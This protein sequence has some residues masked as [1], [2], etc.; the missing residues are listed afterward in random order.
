[1]KA[2]ETNLLK[3]LQ[4]T[5]QFIIPIYQRTYSWTQS[6]CQQLWNDIL[7]AGTD[8]EVSGHFI[9]SV[10]YVERGLY[11]ISSVPQ[12]LVIDGQQRLTTLTL[13]LAALGKVIEERELSGETSRKKIDNYYLF[14][15]EEE[16]E[17]QYKL[18]L[19]RG[20]KDTLTG[21]LNNGDAPENASKHVTDNWDY[22]LQQF[23]RPEVDPFVV[24]GALASSS[25]WTL[26]WIATMTTR[27][28]SSRASTRLG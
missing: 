24:F 7:R 22:F 20:D 2:T 9:G 12:V 28:S 3:F 21:I 16:D 25:S 17:L 5:R 13:L 19:T 18:L 1:M 26:R 27:S 8:E 11:T 14:N 4:G 23:R 15:S 10:V 6:Q